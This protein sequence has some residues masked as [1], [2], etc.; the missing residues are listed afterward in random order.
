[1]YRWTWRHCCEHDANAQTMTILPMRWLQENN[2]VSLWSWLQQ[3]SE[4]DATQVYETRVIRGGLSKSTFFFRCW[5]CVSNNCKVCSGYPPY[6]RGIH[7]SGLWADYRL[8]VASGFRSQDIQLSFSAFSPPDRHVLQ[9]FRRLL[10][11][12]G[13]WHLTI[14]L[15]LESHRVNICYSFFDGQWEFLATGG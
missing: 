11:T 5:F 4:A 9:T 2:D 1:M 14:L 3:W 12:K 7:C 8:S 6:R 15:P 13:N 10:T